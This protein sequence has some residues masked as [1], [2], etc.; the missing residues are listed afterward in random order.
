MREEY[1]TI[2]ITITFN[3]K[4]ECSFKLHFFNRKILQ[5]DHKKDEEF[6][7]IETRKKII[8]IMKIQ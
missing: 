4:C 3:E 7:E 1:K 2:F 6:K 5:S 8:F